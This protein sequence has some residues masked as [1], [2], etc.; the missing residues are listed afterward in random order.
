MNLSK[1]L[2]GK[3][4]AFEQVAVSPLPEKGVDGPARSEFH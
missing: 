1:H 3:A 2:S 4:T